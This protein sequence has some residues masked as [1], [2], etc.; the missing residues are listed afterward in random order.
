MLSFIRNAKNPC[1]KCVNYVK[2]H[3]HHRDTYDDYEQ[4]IGIC[5]LF[6]K[7]HLVT[8]EIIYEDALACRIN[9]SKC[10]EEGLYFTSKK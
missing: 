7:Q 10:G 3:K 6:G 8:G 2:F 9:T 5:R 4:K 1:I